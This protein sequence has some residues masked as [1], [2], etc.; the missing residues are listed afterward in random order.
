MT[1]EGVSMDI[2]QKP[3]R[4]SRLRW[5]L[6]LLM[7]LIVALIGAILY[8]K[9][10]AN[11]RSYSA[12]N[13]GIQVLKSSVDFNGNGSDDYADFLLGARKDAE[14]H[15]DY[16]PEYVDGGWPEDNKGVCADVI[17]R[18]FKEAGY[19]LR[20]MV[21]LDVAAAIDDYPRIEKPDSN[22]DFRRVKNL[23][24][25]FEKYARHLTLDKN[26]ISEW[27]PGDIVIFGNNKHIGIVSD[28]RNSDGVSLIIHN[29][30]QPDREEDYLT[31]GA[32]SI[33]GHY[34][35]DAS[36]VPEKMRIPWGQ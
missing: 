22:I 1:K 3:A 6:L 12:E 2:S 25:F 10:P 36:K 13:F 29:G 24:V 31:Y 27:Q 34:R 23:K 20:A 33:T 35:F 4:S 32:L 21:D 11:S 17:W 14:N 5:A 8:K 15:P 7:I 19:D 26:E 30:G 16:D 18:A 9:K 28:K